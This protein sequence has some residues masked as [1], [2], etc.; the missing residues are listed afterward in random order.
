[1]G[2]QQIHKFVLSNWEG[3]AALSKRRSTLGLFS[4]FVHKMCNTTWAYLRCNLDFQGR[5]QLG[6]F[7]YGVKFSDN[8][9]DNQ[10]E[11]KIF[12]NPFFLMDMQTFALD[13][14][15]ACFLSQKQNIS[16][17]L[18]NPGPSSHKTKGQLSYR[19]LQICADIQK[20]GK[21]TACQS[22]TCFVAVFQ[23]VPCVWLSIS[24]KC[25]KFTWSARKNDNLCCKC[26]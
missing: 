5:G 20:K 1:M 24:L 14:P 13:V 12:N 7:M 8:S 11:Y 16:N 9:S 21:L 10:Q 23:S 2:S 15:N 26:F 19:H 22:Q 18:L 25:S 17:Y 6:K 3:N 4:F